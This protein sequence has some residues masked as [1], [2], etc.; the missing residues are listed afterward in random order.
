MNKQ[1][2]KTIIEIKARLEDMMNEIDSVIEDETNAYEN[3]SESLKLTQRGCDMDDAI[4]NLECAA[5]YV[6]QAIDS[7]EDAAQ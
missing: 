1:R 4:N 3:L 5:D 2:R 7:L 6:K